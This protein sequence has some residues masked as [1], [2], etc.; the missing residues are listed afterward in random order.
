[1]QDA[2]A[3]AH[4]RERGAQVIPKASWDQGRGG[5]RAPGPHR[6]NGPG[7]AD[8]P[9]D[10]NAFYCYGCCLHDA[11]L[12][13]H[14]LFSGEHWR[15]ETKATYFMPRANGRGFFLRVY[16]GNGGASTFYVDILR[17]RDVNSNGLV[18]NLGHKTGPNWPAV[19]SC[20]HLPL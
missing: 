9:N 10:L 12:E 4:S 5:R 11:G 18:F 20:S 6:P 13:I 14:R 15:L 17:E 16:F 1:L 8:R 2:L 3:C 19:G 7:D